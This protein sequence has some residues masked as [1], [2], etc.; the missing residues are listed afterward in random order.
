MFWR[1]AATEERWVDCDAALEREPRATEEADWSEPLLAVG[2]TGLVELV[3]DEGP[4]LPSLV[5]FLLR[6]PKGCINA[7]RWRQPTGMPWAV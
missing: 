5:R 3:G 4:G 6:K 7:L 2:V 1:V